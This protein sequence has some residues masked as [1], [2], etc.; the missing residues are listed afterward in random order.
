MHLFVENDRL[1]YTKGI[2]LG[3]NR[4]VVMNERQIRMV[5]MLSDGFEGNFKD[6]F[7]IDL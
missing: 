4:V 1:Y 3:A 6:W 7:A 2:V 5:N